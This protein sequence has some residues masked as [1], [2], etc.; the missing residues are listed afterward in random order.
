M[1]QRIPEWQI[2][3]EEYFERINLS[4]SDFEKNLYL[5]IV[6]KINKILPL[7]DLK[8]I[9]SLVPMRKD[10]LLYLLRRVSTLNG[11]LPFKTADIR[12]IKADPHYLK[13]GQK[14][15]YRENYQNLLEKLPN[16][17]SE[18]LATSGGLSDL[19]A[20][21]AFGLDENNSYCLACYVPPILEKHKSEII[22][23][24]G[25]H[26]NY[27]I[28][29]TSST[30]NAILVENVTIPFPCSI[31]EW[32]DIEVISLALKPKNINE[33]YFELQKEL[34]RDLKYLGID[35]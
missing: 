28:K 30:I 21:F 18:F 15:V 3:A 16:I 19:G 34:F 25:I 35:G 5:P 32:K 12:M 29:Q 33:R 7:R 9:Q 8:V 31:K 23:M 17:F 1:P 22:I 26:R 10:M 11:E 4:V 14:F 6:Q 2:T 20:F 24:D 27:I 13:I